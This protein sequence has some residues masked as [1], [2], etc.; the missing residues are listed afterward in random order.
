[1]IS[2]QLTRFR[3]AN[4]IAG[5]VSKCLL[6]P[7][8]VPHACEIAESL[9][10]KYRFDDWD[11]QVDC[12]IF[13]LRGLDYEACKITD[14]D[15]FILSCK[16]RVLWAEQ[17]AHQNL[18]LS[19]AIEKFGSSRDATAA[20]EIKTLRERGL[21]IIKDLGQTVID[22]KIMFQSTQRITAEIKFA[23][24]SNANDENLFLNTVVRV[25][26]TGDV[27]IVYYPLSCEDIVLAKIEEL[28]EIPMDTLKQSIRN[29]DLGVLGYMFEEDYQYA[30]P[31]NITR[32]RYLASEKSI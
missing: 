18:M 19:L 14:P 22:R 4:I 31:Q 29:C 9:L 15:K 11:N 13:P 16:N 20:R 27:A 26:E 12:S 25:N 5:S 28:A 2:Q 24:D 3:L 8:D 10:E 32:A 1:M 7:V 17:A 21:E 23:L 6:P 30:N